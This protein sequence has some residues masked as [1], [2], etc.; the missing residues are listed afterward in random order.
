MKLT[1]DI[2]RV[3]ILKTDGTDIIRLELNAPDATYK[4]GAVL[5]MDVAHGC[6]EEYVKTVLGITDYVLSDVRVNKD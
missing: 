4:G 3:Q 1:L 2:K 5:K 6:G